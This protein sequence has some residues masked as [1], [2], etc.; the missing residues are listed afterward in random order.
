MAVLLETK[1]AARN[2]FHGAINDTVMRD[3][4]AAVLDESRKVRS[5]PPPT[6]STA[7]ATATAAAA[8]TAYDAGQ[9]HV[10][11][12]SSAPW[13]ALGRRRP[14]LPGLDWLR[15]DLD[16]RC[17]RA[18]RC[19]APGHLHVVTVWRRLAAQTAGSGATVRPARRAA[20]RP[21]R[22]SRP[23]RSASR[24]AASGTTMQASRSSMCANSRT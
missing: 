19:R 2:L 4:M 11:R 13:H 6:T 17:G 16:G 9:Q 23:A 18:T 24:A 15:L 7:T 1:S 21:T 10:I 22:P 20:R 8:P 12:G 5:P 14:D 3:Q